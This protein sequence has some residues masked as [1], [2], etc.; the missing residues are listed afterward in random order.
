MGTKEYMAPEIIENKPYGK[1]IDLWCLG[2]LIYEMLTGDL[3]RYDNEVLKFPPD[4]SRPAE[5]LIK[6]LLRKDPSLRMTLEEL[7]NHIWLA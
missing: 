3:P 7:E 1:E 4:L 5:D 2:I 6:R